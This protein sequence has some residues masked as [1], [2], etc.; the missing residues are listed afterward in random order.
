MTISDLFRQYYLEVI[1]L[2]GLSDKTKQNYQ[3]SLHSFINA[4]G[5][6]S[7]VLI[8]DNT[9]IRWKTYMVNRAN[10]SSSIITSLG[11]MRK[12]MQYASTKNYEVMDWRDITM[13]KS[14]PK[15]PNYVL[16]DDVKRMMLVTDNLRDKA[17]IACLFSTGCRISELL[18]LTRAEFTGDE[19]AVTGKN[20][21]FRPV[22]LDPMTKKYLELYLNS[23][24]DRLTPLFISGQRRRITVSRVAQILHEIADRAGIEKNVHPHAFRHGFATDMMMNGADIRSLQGALGHKNIQTTQVYTHVSDKHLKMSHQKYH[25]KIT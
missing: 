14:T 6:V 8:E 18:N 3:T 2:G 9:I 23:R 1:T 25:T 19:I 4:V 21:S 24:T 5:D 17:L 10:Q 12:V 15:K 22:Y 7:I 13:P 11:H 16:S 20:G